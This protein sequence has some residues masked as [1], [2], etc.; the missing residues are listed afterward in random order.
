MARKEEMGTRICTLKPGD[1]KM[2]ETWWVEKGN[3]ET[4]ED[5]FGFGEGMEM[6]EFDGEGKGLFL[7]EYERV[8]FGIL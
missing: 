6:E 2:K 3:I 4:E 7:N 5:A 1:S 8:G